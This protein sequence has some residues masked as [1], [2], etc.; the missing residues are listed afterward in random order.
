MKRKTFLFLVSLV[1][2]QTCVLVGHG[3]SIEIDATTTVSRVID[4]DTFDTTSGDRIR[5]AD[6]DA[7]E[8]GEYGYSDA[9]DFLTSLVYEKTVYLDIDDVYETDRY[10]RLVCVVYVQHNS[11]HYKN[12]NKALLVEGHATIWNFN[13]E[14]NPYSWTLFV[15]KEVDTIPSLVKIISPENKIYSTNDVPLTFTI[16]KT[17]LWIGYSIDSQVNVTINENTTIIDLSEGSHSLRIYAYDTGGNADSEMVY[18]YVDTVTPN[19]TISLLGNKTYATNSVLLIFSIDESTSWIG[20]S[21]DG[22]ANETITHVSDILP[23][24]TLSISE[25]SEGPHR[26]IAYAKDAAGNT[27]ASEIIY[28]TVETPKEESFQPEIAAAIGI[29]AIVVAAAILIYLTKF[30]KQKPSQQV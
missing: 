19:I 16:D 14:F 27:G 5:L 13:N 2:L 6:I 20:Y 4:G 1:L 8:S 29:T 22:N 12:I 23:F 18:F 28:F 24:T 17:T 25:L 21:L 3:S 9:K 15:S 10:G 11:T 7:P 26:I 30:K